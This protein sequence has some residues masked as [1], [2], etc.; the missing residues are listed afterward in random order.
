MRFEFA[1]TVLLGALAWMCAGCASH[2]VPVISRVEP[3]VNTAPLARRETSP[4]N[5]EAE[6]AAIA[7][8]CVGPNRT[9][10]AAQLMRRSGVME[11][12]EVSCADNVVMRVRCDTGMCVALP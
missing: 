3:T 4:Y 2:D 6:R 12:F 7:K 5:F 9:R 8:G 10:P 1:A 11:W